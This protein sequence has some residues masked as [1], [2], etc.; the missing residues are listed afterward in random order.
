M[1]LRYFFFQRRYYIVNFILLCFISSL[2]GASTCFSQAPNEKDTLDISQ[3]FIE[4]DSMNS[5]SFDTTDLNFSSEQSEF[6]NEK[7]SP[8]RLGLKYEVA[9]KVTN[10]DKIRRNRL[11][12]RMEYSKS[13]SDH[14]SLQID[15]KVFAFLKNDHR[16]RTSKFWFNDSAKEADVSFGGRT[17]EAYL[18][19][20]FYKT[21]IKAGMQTIAWG[22]S[23]FATV[24]NE[25]SPLDYREP[26]NLNIDELRL[27]Q[28]MLTVDQYSPIGDWN[29]FFTPFPR[30]NQ[31]PKKGTGYYYDPFNGSVEYQK[32]D[33]DE[34][35]FEYGIRWKKTFG[36]TDVSVM[37]ASLINNEYTTHMISSSLLNQS[38]LRYSVAGVTFNHAVNKFLIKGEVAIKSPKAYNNES[39]QVVKKKAL[40]ASLGVEY[41]LSSTFTVSMEAVNYHVI[42]WNNRLL[43]VPK[44]SYMVLLVMSKQLFKNDL[45]INWVTMY[46]GPYSN[47]F[48]LLTTSYNWNDHITF[49]LDALIPIANNKNSGLYIYRDEKL[50]A[51]KVQYQF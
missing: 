21:S 47:F 11:S 30:F 6:L 10:P 37:A 22:E 1:S 29:V 33:Q 18:Q 35:F 28:L 27:A 17:R 8:M 51:F 5:Q 38:K 50:L 24:T 43:S 36:K 9:Y 34:N 4:K 12:F 2:I 40:D 39:F 19:A 13:L 32:E 42:D 20:S 41:S 15:T 49:Y 23:D 16:A 31:H 3:V 46:N 45:S 14:F 44:D 48:N 26:L 25:I 7:E